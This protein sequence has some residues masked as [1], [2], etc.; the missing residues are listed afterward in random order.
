[1]IQEQERIIELK[2]EKRSRKTA[3]TKARHTV[4]RLSASGEDPESIQE[5]ISTLW[6][7]LEVSLT[8]EGVPTFGGQRK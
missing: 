8:A 4:E 3:V 7:V 6:V 5:E 2:R 1:M